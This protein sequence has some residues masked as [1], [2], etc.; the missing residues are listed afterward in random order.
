MEKDLDATCLCMVRAVGFW[1]LVLGFLGFR[2]VAFEWFADLW[3]VGS[4]G[5]VC[6]RALG[7]VLGL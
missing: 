6:L 3:V 4:W 1:S 2:I 5:S 7:L